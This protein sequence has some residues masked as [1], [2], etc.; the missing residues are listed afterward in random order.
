MHVV[1]LTVRVCNVSMYSINALP[2]GD[3]QEQVAEQ[4][5]DSDDVPGRCYNHMLCFNVYNHV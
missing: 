2:T 1:C 3:T 4:D 5:E